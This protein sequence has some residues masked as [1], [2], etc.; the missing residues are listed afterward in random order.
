MVEFVG[1]IIAWLE[2]FGTIIAWLI[3]LILG[4]IVLMFMIGKTIVWFRD[5]FK[6]RD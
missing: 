1:T 6:R 3:V 5:L 2:F 4:W